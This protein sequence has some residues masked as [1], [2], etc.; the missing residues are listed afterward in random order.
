[1]TSLQKIKRNRSFFQR[2]YKE[3]RISLSQAKSNKHTIKNEFNLYINTLGRHS[4]Y[5]Y[6]TKKK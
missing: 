3:L 2:L 1:M 6:G 4:F 5:P